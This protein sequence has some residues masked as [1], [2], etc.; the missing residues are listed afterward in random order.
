MGELKATQD[1]SEVVGMEGES[2]L[3]NFWARLA[4]MKD[5]MPNVG[6]LQ[7]ELY[8]ARI[9]KG[10]IYDRTGRTLRCGSGALYV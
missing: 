7:F 9:Y 2:V 3:R 10:F 8:F 1:V 4:N 6:K 5:N